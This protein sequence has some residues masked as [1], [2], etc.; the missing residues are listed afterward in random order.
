MK[1]PLSCYMSCFLAAFIHCFNIIRALCRNSNTVVTIGWPM[2]SSSCKRSSFKSLFPSAVNRNCLYVDIISSSLVMY[3][4]SGSITLKINKSVR[5]IAAL[6]SQPLTSPPRP[7]PSINK[8]EK[9]LTFFAK[10]LCFCPHCLFCTAADRSLFLQ[11][12]PLSIA[13][14]RVYFYDQQNRHQSVA[15]CGWLRRISF[16]GKAG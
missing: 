15:R 14:F 1:L 8:R 3:P 16:E 2:V 4:S 12:H 9:T 13:V 10:L 7:P 6:Y 5:H 11:L